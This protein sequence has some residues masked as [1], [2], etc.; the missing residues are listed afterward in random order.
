MA[1]TAGAVHPVNLLAHLGPNEADTPVLRS[2]PEVLHLE[3]P[4]PA[5]LKLSQQLQWVLR[6]NSTTPL[7]APTESGATK[8]VA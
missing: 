1:H 3:P 5:L 4:R 2:V 6:A 7:P 8:I